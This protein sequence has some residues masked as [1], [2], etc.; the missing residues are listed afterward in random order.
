MYNRLVDF[1]FSLK[2]YKEIGFAYW[3]RISKDRNGCVY[4]WL[5]VWWISNLVWIDLGLYESLFIY[6]GLRMLSKKNLHSRTSVYEHKLQIVIQCTYILCLRLSFSSLNLSFSFSFCPLSLVLSSVLILSSPFHHLLYFSLLCPFFALFRQ[7]LI[8]LLFSFCQHCM[9]N[10][11]CI[12]R[13]RCFH[14]DYWT[15]R[16]IGCSSTKLC[17]QLKHGPEIINKDILWYHIDP[18]FVSF[19]RKAFILAM[20]LQ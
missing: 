11:E 7:S 12:H 16:N 19:M 2:L 4:D 5:C 3:R 13:I 14:F 15:I 1:Q 9:G 6:S 18:P 17:F 10:W 8:L 20:L